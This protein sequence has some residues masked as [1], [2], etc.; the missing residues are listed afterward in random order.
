[1]ND[2]LLN[3]CR[4]FETDQTAYDIHYIIKPFENK[5]KFQE[6]NLI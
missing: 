2:D 4:L 5:Q 3:E 6:E 1:M